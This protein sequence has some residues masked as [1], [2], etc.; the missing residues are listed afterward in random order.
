MS[1]TRIKVGAFIE[2]QTVR[3][4]GYLQYAGRYPGDFTMDMAAVMDSPLGKVLTQSDLKQCG[5]RY[6]LG[7]FVDILLEDAAF[8]LTGHSSSVQPPRSWRARKI[9]GWSLV[10]DGVESTE[11]QPADDALAQLPIISLEPARTVISQLVSGWKPEDDRVDI[12]G[13]LSRAIRKS[14]EAP[15]TVSVFVDFTSVAALGRAL[16]EFQTRGYAA[17]ARDGEPRGI[18]VTALRSATSQATEWIQDAEK[19]IMEI[20]EANKGIYVGGEASL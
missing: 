8:S 14:R 9:G 1:K 7:T 6:F 18:V 13:D 2:V 4:V 5:V 10:E 17:F 16:K 12:I 20:A 15:Q 3:G 19:A 11:I